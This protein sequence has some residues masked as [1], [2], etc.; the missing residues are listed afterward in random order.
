MTPGGAGSPVWP[1][2][3]ESLPSRPMS[4]ATARYG[5]GRRSKSCTPA[6]PRVSDCRTRPIFWPAMR[7]RGSVSRPFLIPISR[8]MRS[9]RSSSF[10]AVDRHVQ[11]LEDPEDADVRDPARPGVCSSWRSATSAAGSEEITLA[12]IRSPLENSTAIASA[13]WTTWAAVRTFPS[14]AIRTPDPRPATL[15]GVPWGR[16]ATSFTRVRTTTTDPSTRLKVSGRV[17]VRVSARAGRVRNTGSRSVITM[18]DRFAMVTSD[19]EG[20]APTGGRARADRRHVGFVIAGD[21]TPAV[22]SFAPAHHAHRPLRRIRGPVA[23]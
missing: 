10:D 14:A 23:P 5:I 21:D 7:P 20:R 4:V 2:R 11:I 6:A 17:S 19:P 3:L 12:L 13:V 1:E 22:L 8:P 15:T 9:L 16:G 18:Q